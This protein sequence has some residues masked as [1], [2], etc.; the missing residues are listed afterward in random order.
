[1][2]TFR[3]RTRKVDQELALPVAEMPLYEGLH[4]TKNGN[5]WLGL[6]RK[7]YTWPLPFI[8]AFCGHCLTNCVGKLH[9]TLLVK[10]IR[11]TDLA[12]W[13]QLLG[14]FGIRT[15]LPAWHLN[16]QV[17]NTDQRAVN[18]RNSV[19]L[20]LEDTDVCTDVLNFAVNVPFSEAI[21]SVVIHPNGAPNCFDVYQ[22]AYQT[23]TNSQYVIFAKSQPLP[24]L[25]ESI[26]QLAL[27]VY[28]RQ[29]TAVAQL[30][31]DL[32]EPATE[33]P[34]RLIHA[35]PNCLTQ[36]D[37]RFGEPH[38]GIAA[39]TVFTVLPDKYTCGL[40]ETA[41]QEFVE[42]WVES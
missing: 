30:L 38:R 9:K 17:P 31:P 18:L 22:R 19:L 25:N 24:Q 20:Q 10:D 16:W 8:E 1:M 41:K 7:S 32:P 21:T 6:F 36:Y 5:F 23:T 11:E 15:N 12:G 4:R 34:K 13:N 3:G 35:C 2:A 40:C 14:R 28:E 29:T 37:D 27:A 33:T 39:G 26:R 42:K